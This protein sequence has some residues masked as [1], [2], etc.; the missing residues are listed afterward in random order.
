V[1]LASQKVLEF[2]NFSAGGQFFCGLNFVPNSGKKWHKQGQTGT[3]H[4]T[5]AFW[6]GASYSS[7]C[8]NTRTGWTAEVFRDPKI[9]LADAGKAA[10][11]QPAWCNEPVWLFGDLRRWL[12]E[13]TFGASEH[14]REG[15]RLIGGTN[16]IVV[17]R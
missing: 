17:V 10:S 9:D 1:N 11:L 13:P 15:G 8:P 7:Y 16:L 2:H 4:T 3:V 14:H 6:A 12:N 5:E